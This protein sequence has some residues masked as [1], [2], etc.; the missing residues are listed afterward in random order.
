MR[1]TSLLASLVLSVSSLPAAAQKEET[2]T[3]AV[4]SGDVRVETVASGLVHPWGLA[5][6]PDGKMLVTERPGRLRVVSQDGSMSDPLD[7]VPEVFA[8]NQGG[9]L[10]I[11]LAPDFE[12]SRQVYLT[13]AEPGDGGVAGTAVARGRLDGDADALKDVEV[14]FR[15]E[16]KVEGS[17]H[18]GSRI[19]FSRDGQHMFVTLAERDKF[20][21]A[22]D[23]G[24][25]LGTVVRLQRDGQTPRDNPFVDRKGA[26]PEIWSYGHR[27]IQAAALHPET[28]DLLVAEMGPKGG[29]ELNRPEAG[30]NFGWPAVSWGEHYD[31]RNIPDPPTKPEFSDALH[32]WTPV[33]SPSGMTGY[34]GDLFPAWKGSVLIG[35]LSARAIVRVTLKDGAYGSEERIELGARVRDVA[36]GPDGAVYAIT[37]AQNGSVL[38]ITPNRP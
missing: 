28:G 31:G 27:N 26:P 38:K 4:P 20:D 34:T 1:R 18:F 13:F 30:K 37:D 23:L 32:Q 3:V 14:I 6:L 12:T 24:N 21:P 15:Q 29:D 33:I 25:H 10:D 16:P 19:V 8:Q 11:V 5:F 36:Q 22:Q 9:L 35:G 2:R 7:G 17:K